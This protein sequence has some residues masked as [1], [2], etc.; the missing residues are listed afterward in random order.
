MGEYRETY[1]RSIDDPDGFWA[2]AARAV[3]WRTAADDGARPQ[4]PR[5]STG[6][7]PTAC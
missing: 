2:E 5:R 6:G 3:D 7:S 1:R 4:Q